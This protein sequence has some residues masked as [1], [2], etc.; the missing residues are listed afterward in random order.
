MSENSTNLTDEQ[1]YVVVVDG[2]RVSG[3]LSKTEADDQVSQTRKLME[4]RG[5][6]GAT[7]TTVPF[8][9]G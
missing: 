4:S 3:A 8:L 5:Q 2:A 6:T 9:L 1:K 7:V